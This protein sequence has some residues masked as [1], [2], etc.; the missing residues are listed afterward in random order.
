MLLLALVAAAV[1]GWLWY[2]GRLGTGMERKLLLGA[3]GLGAAWLTARG[4]WVAGLGVGAGAALLVWKQRFAQ[5]KRPSTMDLAEARE[6][7]GVGIGADED[8]IRRAHRR[9]IGQV[10]PDKGGTAELARR[11]NLARD[12]LLSR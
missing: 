8:E 3:M 12:T 5:M 2:T 6:V 1:G 4:Q 11:V 7:L 9:L 10:H